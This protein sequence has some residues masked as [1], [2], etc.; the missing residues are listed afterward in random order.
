MTYPA[1]QRLERAIRFWL[2]WTNVVLAGW[3]FALALQGCGPAQRPTN[4]LVSRHG[5]VAYAGDVSYVGTDSITD[6]GYTRY[7]HQVLFGRSLHDSPGLRDQCL[8]T[9]EAGIEAKGLQYDPAE[10]PLTFTVSDDVFVV[11]VDPF[12]GRPIRH[13]VS[14]TDTAANCIHL[15]WW[16]DSKGDFHCGDVPYEL[17]NWLCDCESGLGFQGPVTFTRTQEPQ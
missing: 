6:V 15:S 7:G 8:A 9:I 17:S 16:H 5:Y 12:T 13:A 11:T 2:L 3:L 10:H 1:F 14:E 4:L